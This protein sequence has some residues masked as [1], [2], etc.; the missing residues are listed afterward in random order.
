MK[1]VALP[2]RPEVT[3]TAIGFGGAP[4]GGLYEPISDER[5]RDA[6]DA[7]WDHGVRYFD[8]AP[9]YGLGLS[10]RRVGA[11]LSARPGRTLSTKVGRLLE[12]DGADGS[13]RRVRDYSR[14]G[15]RRSLES[16][17]ER[18]G[19]DRIDIVF[20][21]DPDEHGE[22]ARAEAV[23]ALCELRD[24]GVI[25]AVGVGM[26]Q[27]AMLAEFI[28]ETDV[29]LVMCAGR[30]SL[31]EQPALADLLPLAQQHQVG[32][33]AAG[34]FNS[35][36]LARPDPGEDATYDYRQA[37]PEVLSRARALAAVCRE[38][39]TSLPAAAMWFPSAHPAVLG[40]VLGM[41]SADEVRQNLALVPPPAD[42]WR[43]LVARGL[44]APDAIVPE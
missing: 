44:L 6:V 21:H 32:V 8:T 13:L 17:L 11:A 5:A 38:H 28:A 43:D 15:V 41:G 42:L 35:G 20:V 7:A 10:E 39:G 29:D 26:N 31:L 33:L 4:I 24:Q 3:V 16:S 40:V 14:D 19:A 9:H 12:P 37:P 36:L 1:S 27:S 22:Q 30:Y 23:P 18:L 34:V 25:G 2:R